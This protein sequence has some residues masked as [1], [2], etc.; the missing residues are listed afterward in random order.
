MSGSKAFCVVMQ[1]M[2]DKKTARSKR[3]VREYN[4]KTYFLC[5]DPC[6]VAFDKN[7]V[8]YTYGQ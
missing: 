5:C 2:T 4:G 1:V 8:Q 7:P 3:R 6:V